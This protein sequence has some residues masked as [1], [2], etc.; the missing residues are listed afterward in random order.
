M[1]FMDVVVKRRSIRKYKSDP[2][3]EAKLKRVLEAARL[4]PSWGNRQCWRYIIVSDEALRKKIVE[5]AG[6]APADG[7]PIRPRDWIAQAPIII[8]GCADPT[9]SGDK[10]GKLYYLLDMGISIEHL[11]LAAANEGLGTCWIGGGFDETVV[12]EA[13]GI[14]KEIKVVAL[15]PLGYPDEA[16]D[17]RTRNSLEEITTKNHW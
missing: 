13:L 6:P 7:R 3:P 10:E 14:L 2:I 9:K 11:I 17:P 4:A 1:E 12:K 8:V 5:R 16:P 15:V